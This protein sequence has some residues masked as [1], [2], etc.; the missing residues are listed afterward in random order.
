MRKTLAV[1]GAGNMGLAIT[2]GIIRSGVVSPSE[3]TLVRR[4]TDKLSAYIK[5]GLRVSSDLF[6]AAKGADTVLLCVKPQ[7]MQELFSVIAP[8]CEGKL[9]ISIAA[10]ITLKTVKDAL[11]G[12]FV[13]RAMPNTP[14]TVGEGVTELC[15]ADD[16]CDS[17]YLFA[18]SLFEGSGITFDCRE[19]EIN[20]LTSLT[21]SAV[22]YFAAVEDAMCSWAE[23]NGLSGYDRQMICDLVSKTALGSAKLLYEKKIEPKELIR[24]VASPKG[25]TEQAL[26][27]FE[28]RDLSGV[29]DSAMTACLN[30]AIEL[31][32]IK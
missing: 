19:E 15:R 22:A 30:R 14:L 18:K 17:D 4:N 25:T 5:K 6:E 27:V 28:E 13:V 3:I 16:V 1:L 26:R 21:S 9:V 23:K 20:A 31:S 29:F 24:S 8:V 12:A 11:P 32:N 10:G 2:D 7:M